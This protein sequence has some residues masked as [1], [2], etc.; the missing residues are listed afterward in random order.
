MMIDRNVIVSGDIRTRDFLISPWKTA[1]IGSSGVTANLAI[2]YSRL[3][4]L[5]FS[6]ENLFLGED[7]DFVLRAQAL[8]Y[9]VTHVAEMKVEHPPHIY[10]LGQMIKRVMQRKNE[11]L[12]YKKYGE[13]VDRSFGWP[14]RPMAFRLSP[15]TVIFVIAVVFF[16]FALKE[17]HLL[18]FLCV[19]AALFLFFILYFYRYAVTNNF[20]DEKIP[21]GDRIK[22]LIFLLIYIP[23]FIMA[24]I[25]GSI[26]FR[27]FMV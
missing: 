14:F 16:L 26:K 11:V 20:N 17:N 15:A 24:R 22:T 6:E 5:L 8:G 2:R 12:L 27:F 10:S 23:F 9:G 1:P 21:M 7:T 13:K 18:F 4:G 3:N 25:M 19:I